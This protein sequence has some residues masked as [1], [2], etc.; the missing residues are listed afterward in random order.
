MAMKSTS[1]SDNQAYAGRAF[2]RCMSFIANGIDL[3]NPYPQ[4]ISQEDFNTIANDAET[5]YDYWEDNI[6]YIDNIIWTGSYT[7]STSSDLLINGKM[8]ELKY[9]KNK[10]SGTWINTTINAFNDGYKFP[11]RYNFYM[12]EYNVYD[13]LEKEIGKRS[14]NRKNASPVS[15][16]TASSIMKNRPE[17]YEEYQQ[18]E[19][20]ARMAY[21]Y[22]VVMHLESHP[23]MLEK[24]CQDIASKA[25][26]GDKKT[27]DYLVEFA[28]GTK[29]ITVYT[30]EQLEKMLGDHQ[31]KYTEDQCQFYIGKFRCAVAW[32]NG[33]GLYNPTLKI[34]V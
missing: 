22:D 13:A 21:T 19:L 25:I 18:I 16:N 5:L 6:D 32:K 26:C 8:V 30:K 33:T 14:V 31:I 27:P 11:K 29:T 4:H 28:H 15:M 24:F 20:E 12:Q 23:D 3:K 34:Y 1:R 7:G 17:F 9:V 2:E 10:S